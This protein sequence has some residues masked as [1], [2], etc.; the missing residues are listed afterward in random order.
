MAVDA[1]GPLATVDETVYLPGDKV[2]YFSASSGKWIKA[3]V[4]QLNK[5]G[6]YHL[7]VK[8]QAMPSCIRPRAAAAPK[9]LAPLTPMPGGQDA[10]AFKP[11]AAMPNG[12]L[13]PMMTDVGPGGAMGAAKAKGMARPPAEQNAQVDGGRDRRDDRRSP[14]RNSSPPP[15]QR[16]RERSPQQRRDRSPRSQRRNRDRSLDA[17]GRPPLR[18]PSP[19]RR[20]S[21]PPPTRRRGSPSARRDRS[22]QDGAK[23]APPW[24]SGRSRSRDNG[25]E[26]PAKR[27]RHNSEA[28]SGSPPRRRQAS[29]SRSPARRPRSPSRRRSQS[30]RKRSPSRGRDGDRKGDRRRDPS[31]RRERSRRRSPSRK[32]R[33]RN[34]RRRS[35]SRGDRRKRSRSRRNSRSRKAKR[36]RSRSRR[37]GGGGDRLQGRVAAKSKASKPPGLFSTGGSHLDMMAQAAQGMQ[38]MAAAHAH[39]QQAQHAAMAANAA[40]HQ[41][42]QQQQQSWAQSQQQSQIK[43]VGYQGGSGDLVKSFAKQQE[44]KQTDQSWES[45]GSGGQAAGGNEVKNNQGAPDAPEKFNA[46]LKLW[47]APR[48]QTGLKLIGEET[49]A[50]WNYVLKDESRRSFGAMLK[51]PFAMGETA[52]HFVTIRDNTDWKQPTGP[53]GQPIP[54]KTAWMVSSGCS[55]TYRYGRIEV[56]PQEYPPWMIELMTQV[57]PHFGLK[58]QAEWPNSCNLNLYEDGGMSVGWHSDDEKI[59]NGKFQDIRILSL[60]FG[61]KR[62]FEMRSNW[63]PPG[64]QSLYRIQLGDG[65]L[66]TMEGMMQK[67]FQHR[68]PKESSCGP[69]INLTWRWNVK[70]TPKCPAVRQRPNAKAKAKSHNSWNS[71]NSWYGW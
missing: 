15:R 17:K 26:P 62:R 40:W 50:A 24:R 41:Q 27:A 23:R 64:E 18:A 5:D 31:R 35:R 71:N 13:G 47:E 57:M 28:R 43:P 39:A 59:F 10:G 55:C 46:E 33:K 8:K 3:E 42:Q 1:N 44:Q 25:R 9:E 12:D 38:Q 67:H 29:A 56:D 16:E 53:Y 21:S 70:H 14:A 6:S 7:N 36:S 60:S 34:S 22:P 66:C 68:V 37:G 54:R 51:S 69:R 11:Q 2:E 30:R 58:T 48:E 63:S 19:P 32:D 4:V 65:D 45:W 49:G 20:G 61:Q 52:K